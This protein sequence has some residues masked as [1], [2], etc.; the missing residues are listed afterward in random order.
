MTVASDE[1]LRVL[2]G[3]LFHSLTPQYLNSELIVFVC[4]RST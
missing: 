3:K 2:S 1:R 4:G